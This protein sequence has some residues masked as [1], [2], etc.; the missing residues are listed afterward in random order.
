M[1]DS[2]S[3]AVGFEA[4]RKARGVA[5]EERSISRL[6]MMRSVLAHGVA[7]RLLFRPCDLAVK[8][9]STEQATKAVFVDALMDAASQAT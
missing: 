3:R 1:K 7:C 4:W 9:L 2:G 5:T 8:L 6:D